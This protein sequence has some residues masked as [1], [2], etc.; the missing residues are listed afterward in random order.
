MSKTSDRH[1][2]SVVVPTIGRDTIDPCREA[3]ERQTRPPDEVV[4]VLDKD[5]RGPSWA[6]NEGIRRSHGDLIA[7]TDDDCVP[8]PDWLERLIRAIDLGDAAGAGG[9]FE[10]TDPLLRA[11]QLRRRFPTEERTDTAG[12]VGNSGNIMYRRS[13]LESRIESDG[14]AFD[15]SFDTFSGEDVDLSWRVRR[16]GGKMIYV[17]NPVTHLRRVKPMGYFAHQFDRGKGIALLFLAHRSS[18]D[19]SLTPQKGLL[20]GKPKAG[21][22]IDA[23]LQKTIGPF[24]VRSFPGW[25]HF[26]V[27]WIGEKCEGTGFLLGIASP[28]RSR[29]RRRPH[30]IPLKGGNPG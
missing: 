24:D 29:S 5:R 14:Y 12:L 10:E 11:K 4:I 1:A 2:V 30:T 7:F 13:A 21:R 18:K 15:E 9:T 19:A 3:L 25:G 20:W 6:R 26:A 8:P 16:N 23:L 17:P 28:W 22:W 27:F